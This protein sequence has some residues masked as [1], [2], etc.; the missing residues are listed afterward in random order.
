M[1]SLGVQEEVVYERLHNVK[2]KYM[3]M[4]EVVCHKAAVVLN[5]FVLDISSWMERHPGGR[6]V[7]LH[8]IGTDKK[9][10]PILVASTC[11]IGKVDQKESGAVRTRL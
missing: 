10:P 3:T 4:A 1:Y 7:L 2:L 6:T 11:I 9:A 8:R 5:G